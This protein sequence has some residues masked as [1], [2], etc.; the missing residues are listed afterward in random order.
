MAAIL[1][2]KARLIDPGSGIDGTRDLLASEGRVARVEEDIRPA[3]AAAFLPEPPSVIDAEG[4][5]LIPGLVDPHVHFREPGFPAKE[6]LASG[7]RA[8]AAGGYTSVVCEPNTQP[9]I[10]TVEMVRA[11]AAKARREADVRVYFKAAM[12]AGRLGREPSD[13]AALAREESVVALSDD[14][15][16]L[17]DPA[18]M[19]RVCLLAAKAGILL[20]P[21]C[22]DSPKALAQIAAGADP[23]FRP[24][25]PGTNEARYIE[26][27]LR[28]AARYGCRI[29]F[30]HVSLARSV[31]CIEAC[32]P[33]TSVTYEVT[34]HHLILCLEDYAEGE[35][36]LVNPPIRPEADRNALRRAL[37]D[38]SA[39][40]IASDHAPHTAADK[41]A[42]ACGLIGVE[43]TLGLVLTHLVGEGR[44]SPADAV[45]TMSFSPARIFGL[46]C[47]ALASGMPADMALVDPAA[48]WTVRPESFRSRSR[49]T[50]FAGWSLRGTAVATFVG[51][52]EVYADPSLDGRRSAP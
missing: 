39:D 24:G 52:R 18:V 11:L 25:E 29:H 33:R 48:E 14:G 15:D 31:E 47:G 23:G 19:E 2:R 40:A 43:T 13:V 42:G 36:P 6:T 5:W 10:A 3:D 7:A 17:V 41:Q 26:R 30:S 49:N 51:G 16:P 34:P 8:A 44:L 20:T 50:P 4:L 38:G 12:T 1:I 27:D 9:P 28:I 45:R 46:P 35:A 37:L 21:H 22:E 32:Q